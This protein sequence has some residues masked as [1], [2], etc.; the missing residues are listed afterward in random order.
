MNQLAQLANLL[1]A[2]AFVDGIS[3]DEILLQYTVCPL[4]ELYTALA[5]YT[6]AYGDDDIE[7]VKRN[8][9]FN[10]INV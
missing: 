10:A 9:L 4:A 5:F 2:Q 3:L 8:W 7:V 6:I 1:M